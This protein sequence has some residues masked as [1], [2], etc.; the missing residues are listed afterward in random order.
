MCEETQ[1]DYSILRVLRASSQSKKLPGFSFNCLRASFTKSI[2]LWVKTFFCWLF[3]I[4]K[5]RF[6]A[7][8]IKKAILLS[9]ILTVNCCIMLY[10]YRYKGKK[11]AQIFHS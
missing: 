9:G 3:S 10:L 6:F 2:C 8:S 4:V 1:V 7:K 5:P 11:N